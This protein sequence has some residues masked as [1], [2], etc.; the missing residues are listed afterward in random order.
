[1]K[2]SLQHIQLIFLCFLMLVLCSSNSI[3]QEDVSKQNLKFSLE[4]GVERISETN[5][6]KINFD[7]GNSWKLNL[8]E[9]QVV[10]NDFVVQTASGLVIEK[11]QI[12]KTYSGKVD[13]EGGSRVY[14]TVTDSDILGYVAKDNNLYQIANNTDNGSLQYSM[15]KISKI[16]MTELVSI[17]RMM[18][19]C[20]KLVRINTFNSYRKYE[21][22]G[23]NAAITIAHN[24]SVVNAMPLY[25]EDYN[26]QAMTGLAFRIGE[27]YIDNIEIEDH[28]RPKINGSNGSPD[29]YFGRGGTGFDM[30]NDWIHD[31][32][33]D[34]NTTGFNNNN[35]DVVTIWDASTSG[36]C[37][38]AS[39]CA[40]GPELCDDHPYNLC[41]INLTDEAYLQ[42]HEVAHNLGADD[43]DSGGTIMHSGIVSTVWDPVSV[44]EV[45]ELVGGSCLDDYVPHLKAQTSIYLCDVGEEVCVELDSDIPINNGSWTISGSLTIQSQTATSI[46]VSYEGGKTGNA[47]INFTYD[48]GGEEVVLT[49]NIYIG[50]PKP[51]ITLNS[52]YDDASCVPAGVHIQV[53]IDDVPG[54][55]DIRWTLP[56]CNQQQQPGPDPI[57]GCWYNYDGN[58]KCITVYTGEN[59]GHISVWASNPCGEGSTNRYINICQ[60]DDNDD[61]DPDGPGGEGPRIRAV[62]EVA[63]YNLYPNPVSDLLKIRFEENANNSLI[64]VQMFDLSG[65][66][67]MQINDIDLSGEGEFVIPMSNLIEGMYIIRLEDTNGAVQSK[68]FV[69]I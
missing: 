41:K 3:A 36:D 60:D 55:A 52:I 58:Q 13:N 64:E 62:D 7:D 4:K 47:Y 30:L 59:S 1:M 65:K 42:A 24:I 31:D 19:S 6:L 11:D 34:P 45:D 33:F 35:Y 66:Q 29:R 40:V 12:P 51:K 16:E 22:E 49:K 46:C 17:S 20:A 39:G 10:T 53:C 32:S 2:L 15:Q 68:K 50:K 37:R 63:D 57:E 61:G 67:M 69:K 5:S 26:A 27:I 25:Y 48:C 54:A 23:L 44:T 18:G 38:T 43:L 14:L 9:T 8:Q 56:G 28:L 21:E